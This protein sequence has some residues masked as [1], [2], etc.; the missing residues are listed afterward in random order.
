MKTDLTIFRAIFRQSSHHILPATSGL[1]AIALTLAA[2]AERAAPG[3]AQI[4]QLRSD[5]G[6]VPQL[7]RSLVNEGRAAV[8]RG[9]NWLANLQKANGGWSDDQYPALT[10]LPLWAFAV[11][12]H[13]ERDGIMRRAVDHILTYV[14]PD[15]GIYRNL[16]GRRG[17]GLSNYNTA[18]C[19]TALHAVGDRELTP[20]I[21]A[22]RRF[23]AAAQHRGED[24]FD[25]GM[26]YDRLTDRAYADLNNSAIAYEAMRLTESVEEFRPAG[27]SR[28][29]LDWAAVR[30]FLGRVQHT[31]EAGAAETGGFFYRPD[32]DPK[33][34]VRTNEAGRV[35]FRSY[36]SMTY[37]GMLSLIYAEVARDDPRVRSA[38]DWAM[39]HW[40]LEENP[41]VGPE[42]VFYFYNVL[43][44]ALSVYGRN[45]IRTED[46]QLDW[47]RE[48]IRKL[49]NL[50]RIDPETGYGYWVNDHGRYMEADPALVTAYSLMA[51]EIALGDAAP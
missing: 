17:G 23:L 43:T 22:A 12:D 13:P 36:G 31:A 2:Q 11:G 50:Q 33:A 27:S 10:A 19:M 47:R 44:K 16:E 42:G 37:A 46:A 34:G 7:D 25:G 41:G 24:V 32:A 3:G 15:G 30:H 35:V 38:F 26:G 14:Q 18:I 21:L 51:L 29:D 1:L 45:L 40:N 5:S 39:R 8:R 9:Q 28:A 20:V 48:V 6:P 4:L 49:V